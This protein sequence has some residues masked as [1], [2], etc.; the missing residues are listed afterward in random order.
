MVTIKED[1]KNATAYNAKIAHNYLKKHLRDMWKSER[2]S[3]AASGLD[4][5]NAQLIVPDRKQSYKKM[6]ETYHRPGCVVVAMALKESCWSDELR[7]DQ[8]A[9]ILNPSGFD[10]VERL[11]YCR[12]SDFQ[13]YKNDPAVTLFILVSQKLEKVEK[14]RPD[15]MNTRRPED[16]GR[17][18][19]TGSTWNCKYWKIDRSGYPVKDM[20]ERQQFAHNYFSNLRIEKARADF[21]TA[22]RDAEIAKAS[23]VLDTLRHSIAY[24]VLTSPDFAGMIGDIELKLR[25]GVVDNF[26]YIQKADRADLLAAAVKDFTNGVEK[27]NVIIKKYEVNEEPATV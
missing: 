12:K 2:D 11:G 25:W 20:K 23:K 7:L 9:A 21:D 16:A 26:K 8:Y 13:Q 10:L 4:L 19:S 3:L 14:P 15:F 1:T 24:N 27:V 22:A 18:I 5:N 17:N 6:W